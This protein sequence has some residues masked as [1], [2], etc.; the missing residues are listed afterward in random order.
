MNALFLKLLNMSMAGCVLILAV[1]VL[2]AVLKKAPRWIICAMWAL[3]AVQLVCPVN[4]ASPFSVFQATPSVVS[5]N[6]ELQFFRF[7]GGS[8]K[9]MLA[10]DT[11]QIETPRTNAETIQNIPGTSLA[12]TQRSR[13]AY[14]PPLIQAY[15]LGLTVMLLYAVIS[16]LLLRRTVSVSIRQNGNIRMCD[17]V[18]SPFILGII[19]PTV[20]LPSSISEEE[21]RFVL[22]HEDAHL[23]RLDHVWK[24]LGFLILSVHWFNPVC[25]LAYVLLCRDIELACDEKVISE[26][27]HSERVAYSQTLLN[28]SAHRILAACPVAFG[29]TDVK[30]RIKAVMNYRKPAFWIILAAAL[31]CIVLIMCFAAKPLPQKQDLSFLNYKNAIPLIG[32]SD[33]AP[34]AV[35]C[36]EETGSMQPGVADN[37]ELIRFLE[38]A[39]WTKQR[40][41]SASPEPRG[42]I[43]FTIEEDYQI[44]IYEST[45]LAVVRFGE[46]A[47][48]YRIGN[49]DFESA[50]GTFI[51]E[52]TTEP[53]ALGHYDKS[54]WEEVDRELAP[55]INSSDIEVYVYAS[56]FF[57]DAIPSDSTTE[58]MTLED[59]IYGTD[60]WSFAYNGLQ[61]ANAPEATIKV[62]DTNGRTLWIM[63]DADA[64]AI[65]EPD[66]SLTWVSYTDAPLDCADMIRHLLPWAR[67]DY[68]PEEG[69]ETIQ[70]PV[71]ELGYYTLLGM[72]PVSESSGYA[73]PFWAG[74]SDS[75]SLAGPC[76]T[77][78]FGADE[79]S[80]DLR[81]E[82]IYRNDDTTQPLREES[83]AI[84]REY[85]E[86]SEK[87]ENVSFSAIRAFITNGSAFGGPRI[88]WY[89][90]ENDLLFT[91]IAYHVDDNQN[92]EACSM[93]E[94]VAMAESVA[95][96]QQTG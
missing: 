54:Y 16:T 69:S 47:R 23:R 38:N 52:P 3:V 64:L 22:A 50:L 73:R 9:P 21:K 18:A 12:V 91:L 83:F 17:A 84:C 15:L 87:V 78:Y 39:D 42:Y 48:Y 51:P 5:E 92:A 24:P 33:T 61:L 56:D 58:P 86:A 68:P 74:L 57:D 30:T 60:A 89:D 76:V 79:L 75:D 88:V 46:E 44:I 70:T 80:A 40:A 72:E 82:R 2:R 11:V 59:Y 7:A 49:G 45:H 36:L 85:Y 93:E 81:Y 4:I 90:E 94:L 43:E 71:T 19:R 28:C 95:T 8:E 29:E 6:G 10:I 53:E 25:W 37:R 31:S 26:L 96:K 63:S 35:Q 14:L 32:Q 55:F 34:H 41:P 66:G 20:Y 62:H 1:V 13:D 27:E 67:G 65:D 77:L